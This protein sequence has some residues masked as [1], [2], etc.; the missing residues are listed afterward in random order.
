MGFGRAMILAFALGLTRDFYS[1]G[2]YEIFSDEMRGIYSQRVFGIHA[3]S[4]T[5]M[6]YLMIAA[7]DYLMTSNWRGQF[8]VVFVGSSLYGFLVLFLKLI[9]GYATPSPVQIM[10]MITCTAVYTAALG[11][12]LFKLTQKPQTLPYLR[13]KMKHDAEDETALPQTEV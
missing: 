10:G 2:V 1:G 3:F 7:Q 12:F 4:L 6:A 11:P 13:L 9:I 8:V 5:F